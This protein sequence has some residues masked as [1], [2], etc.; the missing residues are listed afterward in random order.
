MQPATK[1]NLFNMLVSVVAKAYS[2]FDITLIFVGGISE[3]LI[4]FSATFFMIVDSIFK[5]MSLERPSTNADRSSFTSLVN[6]AISCTFLSAL[7]ELA[8]IK[9]DKT[10]K[11]IISHQF[12]NESSLIR[13]FP[14]NML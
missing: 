13:N 9:I 7:C 12:L 5:R 4:S 10:D 3:I 6:F 8:I 14:R 11:R 1:Y 2:L